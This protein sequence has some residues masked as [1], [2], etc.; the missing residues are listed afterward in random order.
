MNKRR[1]KERGC[2][3]QDEA[4]FKKLNMAGIVGSSMVS[5]DVRGPFHNII[6]AF[7]GGTNQP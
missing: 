3:T 7:P 6:S 4:V 1:F 2:S 5:R